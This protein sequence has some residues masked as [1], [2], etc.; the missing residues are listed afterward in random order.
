MPN[1]VLRRCEIASLEEDGRSIP[2]N[3]RFVKI[4]NLA[5]CGKNLAPMEIHATTILAL[6]FNGAVVF[7]GDGQVT[8]GNT[9][10]KH[11]ANKIRKLQ[12]G[13]VLAGFAG[14]AADSMTLFERFERKLK[15][16]NGTLGRAAVEL[17]KEWRNDKYLRRLEAML[18]VGNMEWMY[19]LTGMGDVIVP[20]DG[21]IGIG[22]GG[23]FALAAARA[24]MRDGRSGI[25]ALE[26]A[27]T[28]MKVAAEICPFTNERFNFEE[29][30]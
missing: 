4:D 9:V 18:V 25:T 28:A 13:K 30:K 27:K 23:L 22:S 17:A 16:Q 10:M 19:L 24:L 3:G 7:A 1:R 6:N 5:K 20:D 26:I 29:L 15:E 11:G 14:S 8:V 2:A 12:D 21:V